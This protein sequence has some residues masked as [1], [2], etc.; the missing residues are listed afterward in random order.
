MSVQNKSDKPQ[1]HGLI[2][3]LYAQQDPEKKGGGFMSY[4]SANLAEV[5]CWANDKADVQRWSP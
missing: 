3:H 2:V 5:V 4:A 1:S